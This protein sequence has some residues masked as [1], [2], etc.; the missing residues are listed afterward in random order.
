MHFLSFWVHSILYST[1]LNSPLLYYPLLYSTRL[2]QRLLRN[3]VKMKKLIQLL[4][5][6]HI[7]T[8]SGN[9]IMLAAIIQPYFTALASRSEN[10]DVNFKLI[11]FDVPSYIFK[12]FK[13]ST[14]T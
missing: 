12:I 9:M 11:K 4:F 8:T 6:L 5:A 13:L 2:H 1:L 10:L 14:I 3:A 7:H